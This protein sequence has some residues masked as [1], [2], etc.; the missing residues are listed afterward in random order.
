[1]RRYERIKSL[2][3]GGYGEAI[4]A[5]RKDDGVRVVIKAVQLTALKPPDRKAAFQEAEVLASLHHPFIV[6]YVDNFEED[7]FLYIVMEYA[8]GGDLAGL[9]T[10]RA[11]KL[12][13]EGEVLKYFIEIALAIKHIHEKHILHRDLKTQNIF[14]TADGTI[15]L[16]D[17]G[18]ARVLQHTFQVCKTRIGTPYYLSPEICDGKSYNSKT[19]IWSLGCI[20]YELCTLKHAFDADNLNQLLMNI[21]RGRHAPIP[22]GFS[23]E[24]RSLIN[25]LLEKDPAKRPTIND[26][27]QVPLIKK[28]LS[29]YLSD[30]LVV[31]GERSAKLDDGKPF[32][33]RDALAK[34]REN[35][36]ELRRKQRR[37]MQEAQQRQ[38]EAERRRKAREEEHRRKMIDEQ[39][40]RQRAE[41]EENKRRAQR[42]VWGHSPVFDFNEPGAPQPSKPAKRPKDVPDIERDERVRLYREQKEEAMRNRERLRALEDNPSQVSA[43]P[44]RRR[45]SK[46]NEPAAKPRVRVKQPGNHAS[47]PEFAAAQRELRHEARANRE[48]LASVGNIDM[49][50]LVAEAEAEQRKQRK[51]QKQ[52]KKP[53]SSIDMDLIVAQAEAEMRVHGKGT[54][55]ERAIDDV[56]EQASAILNALDIQA[57]QPMQQPEIDEPSQT[58]CIGEKEFDLP[59]AKDSDS[60]T[61]RAETIRALLERELGLDKMIDIYNIISDDDAPAQTV[62]RAIAGVDAGYVVLLQQLLVLDE[63]LNG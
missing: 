2:G 7:N 45:P 35:E 3:K 6:T 61:Y 62:E 14:L 47:S 40:L 17:F 10:K 21:I 9:I 18:I 57:E 31:Y 58:Y 36:E 56:Y 30:K 39:Y 29:D 34:R 59:E 52:V 53:S 51:Q 1:M 12:F 16:G 46:S 37:A 26:V 23:G 41:V 20:L 33:D 5:R 60:L 15:K 49:D 48:K 27:L 42:D 54:V 32:V 8:D 43:E 4:L 22:S 63:R 13:T 24:L 25:S 19:D 28:K 38:A 55:E 50:Q 44:E 11:G